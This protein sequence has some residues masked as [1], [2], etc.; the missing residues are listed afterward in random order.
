[1]MLRCG[2]LERMADL[3]HDLHSLD[4]RE[5]AALDE[6]AAQVLAF[7]ELHGDELHAVG[8]AQVVDA[9]NVAMRHLAARSVPA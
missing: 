8:F 7:D 4:G 5:F 3:L 1:M 6:Q 9:D 2:S